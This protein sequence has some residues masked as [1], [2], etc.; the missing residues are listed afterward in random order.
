MARRRGNI[1]VVWL[2][3]FTDSIALWARQPEDRYRL[4]VP[5]GANGP[6]TAAQEEEA[7]ASSATGQPDAE[8]ELDDSQVGSSDLDVDTDDWDEDDEDPDSAPA[9]PLKARPANGVEETAN[10]VEGA[11]NGVQEPQPSEAEPAGKP[12]EDA[13]P[14]INTLQPVDD[15]DEDDWAELNKEV[16]EAMAESDD[17]EEDPGD[18]TSEQGDT[19]MDDDTRRY[20]VL[21]SRYPCAK[22]ALQHQ[23]A[24]SRAQA[25][26]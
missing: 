9:T 2:A 11:T 20:G 19:D 23:S 13:L 6:A 17:D 18:R 22:L 10:G 4:D 16:L 12:E 14:G 8:R 1:D 3:W 21:F 5:S 7:G 24:S 26:T 15:L 25:I